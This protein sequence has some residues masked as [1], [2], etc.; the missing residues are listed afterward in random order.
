MLLRSVSLA[1]CMVVLGSCLSVVSEEDAGAGR[2]DGGAASGQDA[3]GLDGGV[4]AGGA[5]GGS[6]AGAAC[7]GGALRCEAPNRLAE[8][9]GAAWASFP[10]RGPEGC[11]VAAGRVAC[12]LRGSLEGDP[13]APS[14]ENRAVCTADGGG[15]LECRSGTFWLT[16]RCR[17]CAVLGDVVVCQP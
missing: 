2:G 7:P 12:D 16:N 14:I 15:T 5:D 11:Q 1:A 4:D 8:C 9:N 13:C 3:G 10:C 6:D 17:S